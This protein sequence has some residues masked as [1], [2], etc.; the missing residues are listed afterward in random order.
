M[1]ADEV[2]DAVFEHYAAIENAAELGK[3]NIQFQEEYGDVS[4]A[5][6]SVFIATTSPNDGIMVSRTTTVTP[7]LPAQVEGGIAY[8]N[9]TNL[10]GVSG[11][12]GV[13]RLF[14]LHLNPTEGK[15]AAIV[16]VAGWLVHVVSSSESQPI[17]DHLLKEPKYDA[18]VKQR[19]VSDAEYGPALVTM[20]CDLIEQDLKSLPIHSI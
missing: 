20:I 7:P 18:L 1:K 13:A 5:V 9:F 3:R 19:V 8:S 16:K 14:R 10:G 11:P 6:K 15:R 2:L 4:H 17:M 12:G